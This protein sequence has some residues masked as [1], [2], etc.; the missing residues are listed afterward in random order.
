[1]RIYGHGIRRRAASMLGGDGPRLRMAWSL[2]LS[3]PG[4]PVILYG[5]EVGLT[6]DLS[7]EGRMASRVPMDWD[8][9]V[10]QA[11][12]PDSLLAFMRHLVHARRMAPEFGWG[13]STLLENEPP[14][15]FAHRCDWGDATVV[16]VHN[17]SGEPVEAELDVGDRATGADD[18]LEPRDH[19]VRDGRLPVR[20]GPYECRWM[21]LRS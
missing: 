10:D 3:L 16:A 13:A 8:A 5:D 20:L 15:L 18:L 12:H 14:A 21:R 7:L 2:L 1:M 9:V 4:T 17:L 6:E 11:R 19:E